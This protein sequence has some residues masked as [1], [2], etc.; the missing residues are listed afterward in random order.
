MKMNVNKIKK[1]LITTGL[2][3]A[4]ALGAVTVTQA[5]VY[6]DYRDAQRAQR[7]AV[8]EQQK[9]ARKVFRRNG[10]VYRDQY[11]NVFNVN[12]QGY[13]VDSLG[14]VYNSSGYV[15]SSSGNRIVTYPNSYTTTYNNRYVY[16][17]G[18]TGYYRIYRNGSYYN[19]DSRGYELLR[20]AV[21][22][23]YQQGYIEGQ[24]DRMQGKRFD[25][26][27][28]DSYRYGNY[29]YNSY[30]DSGQYQY[31]FRQG[32]QRGYQDGFYSTTRYGYRSGNSAYLLGSVLNSIINLATQ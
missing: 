28:E 15:V 32:F 14:N 1:A 3:L 31:Y 17:P 24:R 23:G 19:T 4:T 10:G 21:N 20:S 16:T 29:G 6:R 2:G 5:Q 18:A 26:A 30:V 12:N 25:Y 27:D 7:K 8:R 9:E 22:S 13:Y 11:G